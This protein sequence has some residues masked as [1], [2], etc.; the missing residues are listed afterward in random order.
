MIEDCDSAI[1]IW[2]DGSSVIAENLERLRRLGKPTLVYEYST[3]SGD[4]RFGELDPKRTYDS[5][6]DWKEHLSKRK[7][8]VE[9]R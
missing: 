5:Y 4:E 7:R 2:V 6:Y 8:S 9:N 3:T 1:V